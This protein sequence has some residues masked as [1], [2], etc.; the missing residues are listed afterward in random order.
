MIDKDTEF[1][2]TLS[3][4]DQKWVNNLQKHFGKKK[5]A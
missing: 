2:K 1:V 5:S 3:C 4:V